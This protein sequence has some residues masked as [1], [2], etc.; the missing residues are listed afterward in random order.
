MSKGNTL[1]SAGKLPE[2]ITDPGV[3]K[4]FQKYSEPVRKKLLNLRRLILEAA[5][6]IP[7]IKEVEETL[8]WG[9]PSY[10]TKFGSTIRIDA[11][12][13]TP[14]R[15]AVYFKCTSR[16]VETFKMVFGN[17]FK[18]EGTRAL[19]FQLDD[20]IPERELKACLTAALSY[21]KVKHLPTLGI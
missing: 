3:E 14:D 20:E 15:Y 4:V 1:T 17:R 2:V 19:L 5:S 13:K 10:L 9:E 18:Y 6:E 7:D 12:S 8:K 16:L 11:K 21:H